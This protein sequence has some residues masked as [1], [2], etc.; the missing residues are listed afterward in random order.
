V[1]PATERE[2]M[3]QKSITEPRCANGVHCVAYPTLGEPSKL[4][5]GNPGPR[6][7]ACKERRAAPK[8]EAAAAESKA[9]K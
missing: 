3:R 8:L 9:V 1:N 7:F 5:R 6:C 4:S 2:S